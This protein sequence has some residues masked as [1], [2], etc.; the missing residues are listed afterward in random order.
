MSNITYNT[1]FVTT[2][3]LSLDQFTIPKTLH[4]AKNDLDCYFQLCLHFSDHQTN[5]LCVLLHCN[6][7]PHQLMLFVKKNKSHHQAPQSSFILGSDLANDF[8][9]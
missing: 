2:T 9:E 3:F 6:L 8:S 1:G 5:I 7:L 4:K